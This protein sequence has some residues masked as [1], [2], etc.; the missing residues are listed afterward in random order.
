MTAGEEAILALMLGPR[1]P[2]E[3]VRTVRVG[4]LL[5]LRRACTGTSGS[6]RG[7]APISSGCSSS[8]G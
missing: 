7:R 4:A 5:P 3:D 6:A 1:R 2:W 8:A